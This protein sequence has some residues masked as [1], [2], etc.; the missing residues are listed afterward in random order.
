MEVPN[1]KGDGNLG[2]CGEGGRGAASDK[3]IMLWLRGVGGRDTCV[4]VLEYGSHSLV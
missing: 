4:Q 2:A 3:V 1:G